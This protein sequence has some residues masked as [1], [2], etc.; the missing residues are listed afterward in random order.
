[1]QVFALLFLVQT[2]CGFL[3]SQKNNVEYKFVGEAGE[4]LLLTPYIEQN[5]IEEAQQLALVNASEIFNN[6]TS[7]SGYFTVDK[8]YDSNL[9]F[10]FFPSENNATTDPVLLW[11]QGGPGSTS[12]FGLFT[13]NGPFFA[14]TNGSLEF[15]E[16]SWHKT[17]SVIYI[18]NPVGAGFS[19]TSDG[20]AQNETKVGED[21]YN[22]LQQFFTL[23]PNLRT[24]EF[25][26][27]GESYAGKYVPALGYTI[28]EKNSHND[29]LNIN[30]KGLFIGNGLCDPEHQL[31]Y[32]DYLFQ[33]GL[34]DANV[35]DI[36]YQQEQRAVDFI[37]NEQY[38]EAFEV[39]DYLLNGDLIQNDTIFKNSTGFNTYFNYLYINS[40]TNEIESNFVNFI[41]RED[42]RH[43]IHVGSA[44][45]GN[46]GIVEDSLRNDIMRSV[47]P[48]ISELLNYY[49][50][51]F[52]NGQLDIIVAYP[53]TVNFLRNLQFNSAE[54]YSQAKRN[55]WYYNNDIAGYYKNAGNLTEVLIRNA[56]HMV[57]YDQP[58]WAFY[59]LETFTRNQNL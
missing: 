7:Y 57:P 10:W 36:F 23:F 45:F 35:R 20:Y 47:A 40:N 21:L 41:V 26:I 38:D 6:L 14:N 19:F 44:V 22:A 53:L 56:G 5:Q 29:S 52:Y 49:R 50:I 1:M 31:K 48:L 58:E 24:N 55:I 12:L 11:L 54:E 25:F 37:Q 30:L 32:G 3:H 13:E 9:F 27:T 42:V 28:Y 33:L 51:L 4:P 16:Y 34:I 43:A 15:R 2:V 39:F 8:T 17:H 59:L 46:N 18:D